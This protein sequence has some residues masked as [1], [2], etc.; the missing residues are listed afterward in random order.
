MRRNYIATKQVLAIVTAA[1]LVMSQGI[2]AM[3]ET[4]QSTQSTGTVTESDDP[5]E[6]EISST[7]SNEKA[8]EKQESATSEDSG[9]A[10]TASS[11]GGSASVKIDESAKTEHSGNEDVAS[12][13]TD[14]EGL[15]SEASVSVEVGDDVTAS[16]NSGSS[17]G[18]KTFT[19]YA[20]ENGVNN[21]DAS[22][23]VKVG[24]DVSS[25][26]DSYYD[27]I[28]TSHAIDSQTYGVGGKSAS[29]S[30]EVG[31]DVGSYSYSGESQG[32][33]TSTVGLSGSDASASIE[34]DGD[35]TATSGF[36]TSSGV[37][38]ENFGDTTSNSSVTIGSNIT[39]GSNYG[40]SQGVYAN[41]FG[42]GANS[43]S[44]TVGGDIDSTSVYAG[45]TGLIATVDGTGTN[46]I[47]STVV[48][49]INAVSGSA[50]A[51]GITANAD[52]TGSNLIDSMVVGDINATS[53]SG[54]AFGTLLEKG[55]TG[56]N[57][58]SSTVYGDISATT[59]GQGTVAS[60]IMITG[61]DIETGSNTAALVGVGGDV[62]ARATDASSSATTISAD[63][64]MGIVEVFV[65]GNIN[66][67]SV[68]GTA[69]SLSDS[70]YSTSSTSISLD[71]G[72]DINAGDTAIKIAKYT[73]DSSIDVTVAGTVTGD[74]HA[75]VVDEKF[76]EIN[77]DN[78]NITVWKVN[79]NSDGSIVESKSD[80]T[81]TSN[82]DS[83]KAIEKQINYII[84]IDD[85]S[86]DK[87]SVRGEKDANGYNTAHE[88]EKVYL[89]VSVPDGYK[90]KSFYNADGANSDVRVIST[91]DGRYYLE[92]PKGGGVQVGVTLEKEVRSTSDNDK[93]VPV[94][95][96]AKPKN[97]NH[98]LAAA[99]ANMYQGAN[100]TNIN[101]VTATNINTAT[102]TNINTA[103]ATNTLSDQPIIYQGFDVSSLLTVRTVSTSGQSYNQS[104]DDVLQTVDKLSAVNNFTSAGMA[105]PGTTDVKSAG[106]VSFNNMFIDSV[107]DTV[108]VSIASQV[109][110]GTTYK[111]VLSDGTT[112]YIPCVVDGVL[113]IPFAKTAEG[114][115]FLIYG[116]PTDPATAMEIAKQSDM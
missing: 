59:G 83:T 90:I 40:N 106:V 64:A 25:S 50:G 30:I 7:D 31:G 98:S 94:K 100:A 19:G 53:N 76:G 102:A 6:V 70:P 60:G 43:S 116:I 73:A 29:T 39:T 5:V 84:K 74:N 81:Y 8:E 9:A 27:T 108:N 23:S 79:T 22:T 109:V 72:Q 96:V 1:S 97:E 49:D 105:N 78:L 113:T 48:G 24:D 103:T 55:G 17:Y 10:V 35:V 15:K 44:I 3:A 34:V 82:T 16:S 36:G 95:E 54:S 18:V 2:V 80:S 66:Q 33:Y 11:S 52:G 28:A 91:G 45:S 110:S 37:Y 14:S 77:T 93:D 4:A 115:T 20:E 86:T 112:M 104:I 38:T 69:V 41:T 58:I 99:Y 21:Y 47:E 51:S 89:A 61:S 111:V 107:T 92:V 87:V 65:A 13:M 62:T 46:S 67:D 56:N 101:A 71:V 32:V 68:V 63:T 12:V 85:T 114:V 42:D 75:I 88:G 57:Y 26:S